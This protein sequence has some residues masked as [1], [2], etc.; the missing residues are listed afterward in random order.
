[1]PTSAISKKHERFSLVIIT[2]LIAVSP[3]TMEVYLPAMQMIAAELNTSIVQV[4]YT[5]STFLI[6]AAIGEAIGG[7]I[8]DQLGRKFNVVLGLL[9]F[10]FAS[11]GIMFS[12]DIQVIQILRLF[13]ALGCGFA[14][15]VG[16]PTLRDMFDPETNAKKMPLV[17]A[18]TMIAPMIAPVFGTLLMQWDWRAIFAFLALYGSLVL[19]LFVLVVPARKSNG[20]K[21]SLATL[22]NQYVKVFQFR[23]ND[24]LVAFYYLTLQGFLAGVFLTFLTN[25]SW[26]YLIHFEVT[27]AMLP[28]FFL[29]HTGTTFLG[30]LYISRLVHRIDARKIIQ[31][32]SYIQTSAVLIMLVLAL[33][34][35]L[36][37]MG[38]SILMVPVVLGANM[39]NTS[40]RALL[41]AYFEQLTGSVNS[42][43][44][45][46]RYTF[47]AAAGILSGLLFNNTMLPIISIMLI[48]SGFAFLVISLLLP[49]ST[50]REVSK[51][52]RQPGF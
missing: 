34:D 42:L 29:I 16:L 48:S 27:L 37:L 10:I 31:I 21:L 36:S 19:I 41:L 46:W 43:L 11:I 8:S 9:I 51:L 7:S 3:F 6:G 24:K 26:I 18:A 40:L 28:L 15:V 52:E 30:N 38:F 22:G 5:I 2:A 1:M 44:S 50:L 23:A 32:G 17:V 14:T 33:T 13:Q 39:M 4:N 35:K 12:N 49:K 45:L 25:A 47:G 20:K